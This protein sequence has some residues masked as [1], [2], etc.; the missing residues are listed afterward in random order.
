MKSPRELGL[1]YPDWRPGQRLAIRTALSAK[2]P[3]IIIQAPTGSGKSGIAGGIAALDARRSVTLTATKGLQEQ[4]RR[5]LPWL[6]DVRGMSNYECLAAR[7]EFK[8]LFPLRRAGRPVM[9]DDGPCHD[10]MACT[11]KEHGCLYFDGVREFLAARCGL[12]NYAMWLARRRFSSGLGV[13]QRLIC[14]EAH[15]LPEQ[16]CAAFRVEIPGHILDARPPR[17]W[18]EW[19]AWA[20]EKRGTLTS[21]PGGGDDDHRARREKLTEALARLSTIDA[22]WAWDTDRAGYVFEP[23]I[24]RLLLPL[25]QT[26]DAYSS[27]TYL[28]ATITPETLGLLDIPSSDVTFF[29]LPSTFPVEDRPIWLVPGVW[30]NYKWQGDKKQAWGETIDA[31]VDVHDDRCGLVHTVSFD[32]AELYGT[33]STQ[34]H[35]LMVH[36]RRE[37]AAAFVARYKRDRKVDTVAVS[38]SLMTG[39]DFPDDECEFQVIAKVPFPDTSSRIMQARIRHTPAYRP[40]ATMTSFV[41]ACGRG[42][43][44]LGDRCATF[45]IDETIRPFLEQHGA[46]MPEYV[47]Q[48][49]RATRRMPQRLAKL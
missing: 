35:R 26:F 36:H 44:R 17:T 32:R 40:H 5:L 19:R 34:R 14:D 4:Y 43:R 18:Q 3:H 9:C 16:L 42:N 38:P 49:V 10:G 12:T 6:Y 37:P 15:A 20:S 46:L 28:S 11:L 41:Q 45:V 33:L 8:V 47:R 7:D 21:T 24:P 27:V 2:T 25:L 22:T 13:A 1:P 23:T 30:V 29:S 39:Y 48:A 31:I